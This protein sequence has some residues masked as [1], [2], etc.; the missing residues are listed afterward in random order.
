MMAPGTGSPKK[1]FSRNVTIAGDLGPGH[2]GS[3]HTSMESVLVKILAVILALSQVSTRPDEVKTH[4]DNTADRAQVLDLL[5]AGCDHM[6][7]VFKVESLPLD[8]LV[9]TS[10][11]A[12]KIATSK[13]KEFHGLNFADLD[14]TYRELCKNEMPDPSPVDLAAV[15]DFYD[16]AAANLPDH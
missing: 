4:F 3:S 13:V 9:E 7:K 15:I 11:A 12:P 2:A 8:D 14:P 10:L 6:R 5:R 1:P 16:K